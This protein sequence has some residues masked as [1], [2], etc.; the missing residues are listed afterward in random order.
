MPR[1]DKAPGG[2]PDGPAAEAVNPVF[3]YKVFATLFFAIFAAVLGMGIVVPL[4]PVYAH[5]LGAS[6]LYIGLIFGAFS[7]SRSVFLPYF[8]RLSDRNGRKGYI[9]VG[10]G[11]YAA[12]SIAFL[13]AHDVNTLIAIRFFQGI[14]SA[15][16]MPVVQ[17][18]VG[19]I[20][21]PGRE[22]FIMGLFNMSM[23]FGLSFGPLMGGVIRDRF[24]LDAAFI[25]MGLLA[26]FGF[27][28]AWLFLPPVH[29]ESGVK[30]RRPQIPWAILLKDRV[31]LALFGYRFTYTAAVGVIW[32]FLPVL[33]DMRLGLDSTAIGFLVMLG[34]FISGCLNT[35]MGWVADRWSRT[36]LVISGGLMV[37]AALVCYTRAT[38]FETL[39]WGGLLFG[40]G[41]GVAMPALMA[42][43]V[44]KGRS[45]HSMGATMALL[46]MA[47]SVGMLAGSL[48]AGLMMDLYR[49]ELAFHLGA[50]IMLAGVILFVALTLG[51][52]VTPHQR[53]STPPVLP[54]T[55]EGP[56]VG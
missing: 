35:P 33:A 4:L 22:G 20:T 34:V 16:I 18:Y 24:S 51:K 25:C 28:L 14:A 53:G 2:M 45:N 27:L 9:V 32:G 39:V 56:P 10:L 15:M 26:L 38:T 23:F 5:D 21:P 52:P 11:A 48:L 40:A 46:T 43:A 37:C 1:L 7:L 8:G 47:Q 54:P 44:A 30:R 12:I 49:L 13:F 36:L 17:A 19:D 50:G 42:L 6:G 29:T 41:G 3:E 31:I 55:E